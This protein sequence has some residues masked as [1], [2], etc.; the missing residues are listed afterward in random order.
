MV[1][2]N[3]DPPAIRAEDVRLWVDPSDCTA[4]RQHGQD[5]RAL[6]DWA[7]R[8]AENARAGAQSTSWTDKATAALRGEGRLPGRQQPT[9]RG[10]SAN[11]NST[12]RLIPARRRAVADIVRSLHS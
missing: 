7:H 8:Q 3:V 12:K 10:D 5:M 11:D 6:M 2:P 9:R 4:L 1:E